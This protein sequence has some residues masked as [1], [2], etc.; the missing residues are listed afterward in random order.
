MRAAGSA[1]KNDQPTSSVP[2]VGAVVAAVVGA[3]VAA[4]VA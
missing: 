2:V 4:V 1:C 3:V